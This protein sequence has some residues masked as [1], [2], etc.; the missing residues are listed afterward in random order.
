MCDKCAGV[1]TKWMGAHLRLCI[2]HRALFPSG[3]SEHGVGRMRGPKRGLFPKHATIAWLVRD[4]NC[5][6]FRCLVYLMVGLNRDH[7]RDVTQCNLTGR[8]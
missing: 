5:N 1:Q 2:W 3:A 8:A 7:V 4:S 6:E